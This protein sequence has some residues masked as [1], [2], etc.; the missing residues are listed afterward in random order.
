MKHCNNCN[1]D[2]NTDEKVCP[3]CQSRLT[4]DC[5]PIFPVPSI[6]KLDLFLN[7]LLYLVIIGIAAVG[8]IDYYPDKTFTYSI[9]VLCGGISGYILLRYFFKKAR[10]DWISF[11]FNTS[12]ICLILL[13]GWYYFTRFQLI[14]DYIVPG[15]TIFDL[16]FSTIMA[17]ILKQRYTRKYIH[18][19]VM[20]VFFGFVP[21]LL[22]LLHLAQDPMLPQISMILAVVTILGLIIF[23]FNSLKEEI[24]RMFFI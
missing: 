11:F 16:V 13:A 20:N 24:A 15:I 3:L 9:Y 8:Y 19:I 6:K 1:I 10:K 21:L 14:M 18:I 22:V 7:I 12:I 17:L 23:D 2:I 4:G 5:T